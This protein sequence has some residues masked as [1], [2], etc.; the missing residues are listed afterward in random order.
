[1]RVQIKS[2]KDL[3]EGSHAFTEEQVNNVAKMLAIQIGV[4]LDELANLYMRKYQIDLKHCIRFYPD[5]FQ[6][7]VVDALDDLKRIKDFHPVDHPNTIKYAAYL[8]YWFI[9]RKPIAIE[10]LEDISIPSE[11]KIRLTNINE[12]FCV[13]FG[14][15][16]IFN[17]DNIVCCMS[18]PTLRYVHE[19]EDAE[20]YL[21]YYFCYRASSPKNIEAFLNAATLH[22]YWEIHKGIRDNLWSVDE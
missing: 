1:M 6:M 13:L 22:P 3:L 20:G 12:F 19:W 8:S 16:L 4:F 10:G 9:Q 18:D 21:F 14:L 5:R 15:T 7:V 2:A 17:K 11:A